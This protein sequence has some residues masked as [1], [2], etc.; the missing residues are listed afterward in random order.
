MY[1]EWFITLYNLIYTALPVLGMALFDQVSVCVCV[2]VI[3]QHHL[4]SCVVCVCLLS[5]ALIS[6]EWLQMIM[7]FKPQIHE[8]HNH[9]GLPGLF[10]ASDRYE[11]CLVCLCTH[12]SVYLSVW[13]VIVSFKTYLL[14]M[15]VCFR[16]MFV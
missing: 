14:L 12:M 9:P 10:C 5:I 15:I 7:L 2:C 8:I 11:R 13:H 3:Y 4:R 1:D 6:Y 16:L